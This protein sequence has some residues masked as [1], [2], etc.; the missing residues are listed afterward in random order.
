MPV[1]VCD[2]SLS[3]KIKKEKKKILVAGQRTSAGTGETLAR[4][5]LAWCDPGYSGL[6][7]VCQLA[8]V[9]I[10]TRPLVCALQD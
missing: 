9:S 3:S 5:S 8:L 2:K 7:S 6:L 10:L 4:D 1:R